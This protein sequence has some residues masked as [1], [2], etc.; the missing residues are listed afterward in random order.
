MA[1]GDLNVTMAGDCRF[2]VENGNRDYADD[3][4]GVWLQESAGYFREVAY[5]GFS[6][7]GRRAGKIR[8]LSAIDHA[9]CDLSPV[10]LIDFK[11]TARLRGRPTDPGALS[12]HVPL[13]V[14][15]PVDRGRP[16][17][18]RGWLAWLFKAPEFSAAVP[19]LRLSVEGMR[20]DVEYARGM[21]Q[22]AA[23]RALLACSVRA[24]T[25]DEEKR[26]W[27]LIAC[28]ARRRGGQRGVRRAC[29]AHPSLR[30]I[31]FESIGDVGA[32]LHEHVRALADSVAAAG[33]ASAA[34]PRD[35][36]VRTSRNLHLA[37]V[38]RRGCSRVSFRRSQG[39]SRW[40]A[41]AWG[42]GRE[43]VPLTLE[44]RFRR[45]RHVDGAGGPLPRPRARRPA[46]RYSAPCRLHWWGFAWAPRL[47]SWAGWSAVRGMGGRGAR[48][49][50]G[51]RLVPS[52]GMGGRRDV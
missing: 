13:L 20:A 48:V 14:R 11:P 15:F 17:G 23:E 31:L 22:A 21:L 24:A 32:E 3:A 44:E 52:P 12:D 18:R 5:E 50:G 41:V 6:R 45:Q 9:L 10:N 25:S 28:R 30:A 39:G 34:G 19:G 2:D 16:L 27:W 29:M 40:A 38:W 35:V 47:A 37:Q 4:I 43:A 8:F 49:R 36:E 1:V 26:Y 51:V 33:L 42:S 7:A 46:G